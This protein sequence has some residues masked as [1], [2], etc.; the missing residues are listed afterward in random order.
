MRKKSKLAIFKKCF[1]FNW[2]WSGDSKYCERIPYLH[3][4]K[5]LVQAYAFGQKLHFCIFLV[6]GLLFYGKIVIINQA[7]TRTTT[8]VMAVYRIY[9]Q[10]V[11]HVIRTLALFSCSL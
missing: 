9:R 4:F 3:L 1:G 8:Q 5:P 7:K 6:F 10:F 11:N 2:G